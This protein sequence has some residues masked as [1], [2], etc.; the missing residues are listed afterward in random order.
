[1]RRGG[2]LQKVEQVLKDNG[3]EVKILEGIQPDPSVE[4]VYE[5]AAMMREFNP[6]LIVSIGGG[7]PIDATK[8]MWIFYEHPELKFE[9]VLEGKICRYFFHQRHRNGSYFLLCNHRLLQ[10]N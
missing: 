10:G 1:M 5:G 7:S 2:F 8:A 3:M 4:S 9:D 6:D